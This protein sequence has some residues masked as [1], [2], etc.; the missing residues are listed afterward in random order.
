VDSAL[1]KATSIKASEGQPLNF[2]LIASI[3]ISTRVLKPRQGSLAAANVFRQMS[4]PRKPRPPPAAPPE[5][6]L[7]T[8]EVC[9]SGLVEVRKLLKGLGAA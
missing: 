8:P 3:L 2:G 6:I 5:P 9:E 1:Q 7:L 4:V